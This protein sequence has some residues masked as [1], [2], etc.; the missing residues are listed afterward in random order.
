MY[1]LSLVPH[2]ARERSQLRDISG[3]GPLFHSLPILWVSSKAVM[4]NLMAQV[5]DF[6]L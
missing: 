6:W 5:L 3:N 4:T 1:E 2:Q